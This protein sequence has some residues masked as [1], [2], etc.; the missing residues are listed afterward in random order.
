MKNLIGKDCFGNRYYQDSN[1]SRFVKYNGFPEPT[2]IDK[3]WH[4]WLHSYGETPK[5]I[6]KSAPN[7]SS[8]QLNLTGTPLAYHPNKDKKLKEK[9][10]IYEP[11]RPC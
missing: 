6:S 2:K 9:K 3:A 7:I 8:S 10:R 11:W 1:G 4:P 5:G